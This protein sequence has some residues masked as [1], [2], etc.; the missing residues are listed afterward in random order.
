MKR[1]APD[2]CGCKR[3]VV[4]LVFKKYN[5]YLRSFLLLT[6]TLLLST[7]V[8]GATSY[9]VIYNGVT[10]IT[11]FNVCRVVS[12]NHATGLDLFVPTNSAA[13]WSAFVANPP[14]GVSLS[15]CLTAT[16]GTI[17]SLSG[18]KIHQFTSSGTFTPSAGLAHAEVL[19]VG[20]GGGGGHFGGGGGAGGVVYASSVGLTAQ[21][22]AVTVG[23]GGNGSQTIGVNGSNGGDSVFSTY[24]AKG[25]GGGGGRL[26]SPHAGQAGSAGGSGGGGSHSNTGTSATGGAST[27]ATYSGAQSYGNAGGTGKPDYSGG[28]PNHASAGGGG[29]GGVGGN[30]KVGT[31]GRG[32]DGGGDGGVGIDMSSKF[33]TSVGANGWFAG[34]GGGNVYA[35]SSQTRQGRG[36]TGGGGD[37]GNDYDTGTNGIDAQPGVNGTGGGGGG[38]RWNAMTAGTSG[39]KGGSG[40]VLIKY[41]EAPTSCADWY[42]RGYTT[43]RI[44]TITVAGLGM[45]NVYC[46]Q[47]TDGG[48]WMLVLNYLHQGGTNPA[49]NPSTTTLP[50]LGSSALGTDE[51]TITNNWGHT[52][53]SLLNNFTFS[54]M[55]FYC[56]TSAHARVMH[57]KTSDASCMTYFKTGN[58]GSCSNINTGYTYLAGHTANVP[59]LLNGFYTAN[60]VDAMTNFPFYTG[61]T[62]HW[63]IRGTG[64]RWECDDFP[65][66]SANSTLHRIWVK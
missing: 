6:S 63:G 1:K 59:P 12:N 35:D 44:Y 26:A 62:Y 24:T 31:S 56:Q 28:M 4:N 8:E 15:N 46:D 41:S 36:G 32:A 45:I 38:S 13:E 48:G 42:A 43:S 64:T 40:V 57:F 54:S 33:G 17:S 47:S 18:Y 29:A 37:G 21:A 19:V 25:G 65:N 23:L 10:Q 34:G 5:A 66:N 60:G 58:S 50:F 3:M 20:G 52:S 11:E 22:Y 9:K 2:V 30:W 39:G 61:A 53:P 16:G 14:A 51:S 27:Q 7:L 49:T 55:R